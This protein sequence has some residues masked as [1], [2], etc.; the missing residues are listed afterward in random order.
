MYPPP[1][2]Y[3]HEGY[4][5]PPQPLRPVRGVAIFA[6]VA[7]VCD[8]L[9][10][11]VA[12]V[13]DLWYAA[14]L[15]RVI[16]DPD[17]V[18]ESEITAGDV[19]FGL[20]GILEVVTYV[21]AIAAFLVWLFRVRANA[22]ILSPDGHRRAMPWLIFGWVVPI[23]SFWFPKQIVDDVYDA[24]APTPSPPKGLL[25][26]W[27]AAWLIG[28][29]TS[30]VGARMLNDAEELEPLA[31]AARFD[32]VSIGLLLVAAVLAIFVIRKITDAQ[33]EHRSAA[34]ADA[35]P[36]VPGAYPAY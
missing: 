33:E 3:P 12:A 8:S 24:S 14:L 17:S 16:A 35:A 5:P 34:A 9:A 11:I 23:I 4:P 21:V 13:I 19:V 7:L 30:N 15:D 32:V 36:A 27:W 26:A 22:E 1:P 6:V 25:H 18:P 2:A 28:S 10:G 31:G 29:W 20:S